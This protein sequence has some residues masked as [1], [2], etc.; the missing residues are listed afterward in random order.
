MKY[1]RKLGINPKPL[2]MFPTATA[3]WASE[4]ERR[5]V[6]RARRVAKSSKVDA[7]RSGV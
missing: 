6:G 7:S 3:L 1:I 4:S 5:V 2:Y